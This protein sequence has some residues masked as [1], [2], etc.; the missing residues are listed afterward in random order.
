MCKSKLSFA[1]EASL[2]CNIAS[3]LVVPIPTRPEES[4]LATSVLFV[5]KTISAA[6][7]VLIVKSPVPS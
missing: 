1:A 3:G 7:C 2:T 6:F 5:S 4:N